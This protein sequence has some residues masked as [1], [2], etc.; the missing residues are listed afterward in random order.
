MKPYKYQIPIVDTVHSALLKAGVA[1]MVLATGVGK[2]VIAAFITRILRVKTAKVLFL[3][4]D[5]TILIQ[6]SQ[7]FEKV[8]GKHVVSGFFNGTKRPP[9]DANFVF[10]T[11]QSLANHKELFKPDEFKLVLVDEAHHA[12]AGTYAPVVNYFKPKYL[13]GMTATPDRND[14]FCIR[15][16]F[17]EEVVNICLEEAIAKKYLCPLDYRVFTDNLDGKVMEDLLKE[18]EDTGRRISLDE[19]NR[20]V[21][22]KKRDEEIGKII[23]REANKRVII[24]CRNVEHAE[25]FVK[26]LP[27]TRTTILHSKLSPDEQTKAHEGFKKGKYR[28]ILVVDKYNE[29]VDVPEA[30]TVVFLRT[31]DSAT[32]FLQQLGRGLRKSPGKKMLTVLDFVANCDRFRAVQKMAQAVVEFTGKSQGSGKKDNLRISGSG[33]SFEFSEDQLTLAELMERTK[34]DFYSYTEACEVARTLNLKGKCEYFKRYKEDL[35]LPSDPPKIYSS[36]WISWPNFLHG[37]EKIK[38]YSFEDACEVVRK[39]GFITLLDYKRKYKEDSRLPSDPP[40]IYS[41]K[42]IS[43]HHFFGVK[44]K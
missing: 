22:I 34:R 8:M 43:W 32:I 18:A 15:E 12:Q 24:F 19:I 21:F 31:T 1:L 14:T 26:Q 20:S 17:G 28:Y 44:K 4:H 9:K 3:C 37:T 30:D 13:L 33:F 7:T 36:K 38:F 27:K 10:A 35:R 42:W 16:I 40:K 6:A 23:K 41:S 5:I 2:T 25:E 39:K 11:F 29:G